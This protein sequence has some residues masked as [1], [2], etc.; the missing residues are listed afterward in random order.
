LSEEFEIEDVTNLVTNV[1]GAGADV[2]TLYYYRQLTDTGGVS[3]NN[4]LWQMQGDIYLN[5]RVAKKVSIYFDKGLYSGF[6]VFGLLSILPANGYIKVGKFTP[7]Y[8]TKLDDHTTFIRGVTGFSPESG[9][10]E[11]TG[12]EVGFAP[13]GLSVTGGFYNASDG[14]GGGTQN[15]KALLGRL[16]WMTDLNEDAHISL[17]ANVF[18]REESGDRSTMLLGGMGALSVGNFTVLGEAD[19]VRARSAGTTT[20]ALV[21]YVEGGY[22][23]VQGFDLKLAYDFYDP[24]TEVTTGSYSRYSLGFEFFPINGVE[25]RPMY[26]LARETPSDGRNNEFHLL[27]HFYI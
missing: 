11:H 3:N 24:D 19:I 9:R 17:G 22:P 23:I 14:F 8:G 4:A 10:P 6:E 7:N 21:L 12:L 25:V 1:L 16:D 15:A 13:G 27:V 20:S 26:R 2:R 18:R 5:F